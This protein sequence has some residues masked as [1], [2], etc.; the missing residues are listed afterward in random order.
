M[1][2]LDFGGKKKGTKNLVKHNKFVLKWSGAPS[3]S[4]VLTIFCLPWS[5]KKNERCGEVVWNLDMERAGLKDC[6]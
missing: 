1:F 6:F 2:E 4:G 5:L 3:N